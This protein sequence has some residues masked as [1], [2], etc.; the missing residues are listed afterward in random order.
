MTDA[1][2]ELLKLRLTEEEKAGIDARAKEAG[3][4]TS[5][6]VREAL[7]G[8]PKPEPETMSPDVADLEYQLAPLSEEHLKR[9]PSDRK[10]DEDRIAFDAMVRE[11]V[12]SGK[13]EGQA[14]LDAAGELF[15]R[16][17]HSPKIKAAMKRIEEERE[18][19]NERRRV[20]NRDRKPGEPEK[21]MLGP[22]PIRTLRAHAIARG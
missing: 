1:K 19:E 10:T 2:T 20:Y 6:F 3:V 7:F 21:S 16:E 4:P 11:L 18:K 14:R 8:Q 17:R 5:Q 9:F 12:Q 15:G 13:S 22:L